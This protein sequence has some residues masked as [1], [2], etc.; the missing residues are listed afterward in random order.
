MKHK[1]GFQQ[2]H[3]NT[4]VSHNYSMVMFLQLLDLM[5]IVRLIQ[6]EKDEI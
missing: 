3:F 4:F 6:K 5:E 2:E 1:L